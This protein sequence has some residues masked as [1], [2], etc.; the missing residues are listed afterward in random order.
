MVN[1]KTEVK[2]KLLNRL[3][4]L[5]VNLLNLKCLYTILLN[6]KDG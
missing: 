2:R 4:F 1:I 5:K 3:S 6:D